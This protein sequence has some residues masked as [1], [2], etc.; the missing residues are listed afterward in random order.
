MLAIAAL[1][2]YLIT[3]T[4]AATP[5]ATKVWSTNTDWN[6]GTLNDVTV[7]N[8]NVSLTGTTTTNTPPP[9]NNNNLALGRSAVSSS[10]QNNTWVA[11][12]AFD[13][14]LSTRWSSQFSDP[15]WI[16][17]NLGAVYKISEVKINWETAYG[18][19]YQIQVSNDAINWTTIYS[20]TSGTGGVNDLTGLSGTGQYVRM[21]GTQRGTQ[22]G[23][24]IYE[25]AVYG[26][27]VASVGTTTTVYPSSGTITLDYNASSVV[28]WD[29]LVGQSTLPTGTNITYQA[30][31]SSDNSTWSAWNST[32]SNLANSQYIQI[33]ATL[34]TSNTSVTP[35]LTSLTLNYNTITP[36]PTVTLSANPTSIAA[37]QTSA[38]TWSSTN[39]TSCTA[40]GAWTGNQ[41]LTGTT[42]VTLNQN[43][44]YNI[45]CTGAGGIANA[46]ATVTVT[47]STSL[48]NGKLLGINTALD[49]TYNTET[50]LTGTLNQLGI[51]S[52][53]GEID[54][55]GASFADPN[56]DGT[57][58]NWIDQMTTAHIVPLP[59]FNQYIELSTIN[60][61]NF[62][63]ATVSWCQAYCAGGTFYNNNS[64]ANPAYA[65]QLLEI[66]NEPYGNWNGYNVTTTDINAYATLL[67]DLRTALN[68]AGLN[69]IGIT[70]AANQ[71]S[72]GTTN[73]DNDLLADGGF[74][75]VQGVIVHPYN[76][77]DLASVLSSDTS[78]NN[79]TGWGMV[80]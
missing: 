52:I 10:N 77:S 64:A 25:M 60:I 16:Y 8:N 70:A 57:V 61:P 72:I 6:T 51:N 37:G 59:L 21:Y 65:P 47:A 79:T 32:V 5:T 9:A 69:S 80:Y 26:T 40:S 45:A 38:L 54:F 42:S 28:N 75:V 43:S 62:V 13:G 58:A 36:A 11:A 39:A 3:I 7:A 15:Q 31:T 34:T 27:S 73:W 19:A 33:Q 17:V 14:N 74:N 49:V 56:Y 20:T 44:T 53:R 55:N 23:Y 22:W 24:S 30:R 66:L 63:S 71:N 76:D 12:N 78:G 41:A 29:S 1:G 48:Y 46:S 67:K 35:I 50:T 18:K 4:H 2:I 68:N